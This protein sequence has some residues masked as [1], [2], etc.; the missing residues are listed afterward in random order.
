MTE[1]FVFKR[2]FSGYDP[3]LYDTPKALPPGIAAGAAFGCGV[4]GFVMG[5]S[6]VW[7]VGPIAINIGEKPFGGDIGFELGFSFAAVG[8]L[9]CRPI[10]KRL[11][12]R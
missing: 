8:Y 2:G 5:M 11:L 6:Q 1:H 4:V 10:E 12:G 3:K 9:I 7:Y